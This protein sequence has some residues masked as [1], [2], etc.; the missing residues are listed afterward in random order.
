MNGILGFQINA[1]NK[2]WKEKKEPI[3]YGIENGNK[4]T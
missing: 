3:I 2:G 1:K 4:E